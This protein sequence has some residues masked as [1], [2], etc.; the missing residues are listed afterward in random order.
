[1]HVYVCV[2][3][4]QTVYKYKDGSGCRC[5]V[6]YS[7]PHY[8]ARKNPEQPILQVISDKNDVQQDTSRET[9]IKTIKFTGSSVYY[10]MVAMGEFHIWCILYLIAGWKSP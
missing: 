4:I 7:A 8:R 10:M 3:T 1:M 2:C 5:F 9:H 6:L